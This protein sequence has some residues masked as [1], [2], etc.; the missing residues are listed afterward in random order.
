MAI[1][2]QLFGS[3]MATAALFL[4]LAFVASLVPVY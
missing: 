2:R 1:A 3:I 4:V